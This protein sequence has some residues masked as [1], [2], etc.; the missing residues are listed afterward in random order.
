[1]PFGRSNATLPYE[2]ASARST[3]SE[4]NATG[5]QL[6][7]LFSGFL[8]R[9]AISLCL[10]RS[11]SVKAAYLQASSGLSGRCSAALNAGNTLKWPYRPPAGPSA[12]ALSSRALCLM[13]IV[14][15]PKKELYPRARLTY[16]RAWCSNFVHACHSIRVL[17]SQLTGFG[18]RVKTRGAKF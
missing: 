5:D 3:C 8:T 6:R 15:P 1:M 18:T 10:G 16:T 2:G 4:Q 11:V 17:N 12:C 14:P 13:R 7:F 9:S